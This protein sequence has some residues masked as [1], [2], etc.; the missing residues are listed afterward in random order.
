MEARLLKI[1]SDTRSRDISTTALQSMDTLSELS[2]SL[3]TTSAAL[4]FTGGILT[5]W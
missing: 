3:N 1:P 5:H 4:L 2:F